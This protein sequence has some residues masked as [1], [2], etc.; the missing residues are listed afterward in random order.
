MASNEE[1]KEIAPECKGPMTADYGIRA[2][3]AVNELVPRPHRDKALQ[4]MFDC[5]LRMAKYLSAGQFWTID[6]LNQASAILG[7]P[8]DAALMGADAE[9]RELQD[10]AARLARLEDR[11]DEVVG[12]GATVISPPLGAA[13]DRESREVPP[14]ERAQT[15]EGGGSA[16]LRT[17]R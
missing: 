15:T 1:G 10:I 6:R 9:Q 3:R 5:S 11:F 7:A 16:S 12:T 2:A 8:F 4:R 17:R 14:S 13:A